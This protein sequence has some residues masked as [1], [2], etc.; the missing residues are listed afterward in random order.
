[1]KTEQPKVE[2]LES[3]VCNLETMKERP[4]AQM[5]VLMKVRE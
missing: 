3:L 2:E 1:M 5:T 4:K